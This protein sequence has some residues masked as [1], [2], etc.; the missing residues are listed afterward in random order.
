M[1]WR[2][3]N[4]RDYPAAA[5]IARSAAGPGGR[6]VEGVGRTADLV[7]VGGVGDRGDPELPDGVGVL[8]GGVGVDDLRA[9]RG[10][11]RVQVV[12]G[13]VAGDVHELVDGQ[14]AVHE[15]SREDLRAEAPG[16]VG[17]RP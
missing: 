2:G 15:R 1:P 16:R 6:G 17:A 14:G 5:T 4:V 11:H 12:A 8:D 13:Y 3:P 9:R 10:E 7:A